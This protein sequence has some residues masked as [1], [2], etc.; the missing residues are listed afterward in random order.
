MFFVRSLSRSSFSISLAASPQRVGECV[1]VV[2]MAEV[3]DVNAD[4]SLFSV[5]TIVPSQPPDVSDVLAFTCR[6][7]C[8]MTSLLE[9][10]R[11]R[12]NVCV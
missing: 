11:K 9:T 4:N 10:E 12:S 1:F 5:F 7:I 8:R 3:V 2:M 6:G